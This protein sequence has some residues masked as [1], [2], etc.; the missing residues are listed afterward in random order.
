MEEKKHSRDIIDSALEIIRECEVT[1][2]E[3]I[4]DFLFEDQGL[5]WSQVLNYAQTKGYWK[6]ESNE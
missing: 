4:L 5:E 2:F 1:P 3:Y 6:G